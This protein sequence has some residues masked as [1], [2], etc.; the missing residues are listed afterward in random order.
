MCKIYFFFLEHPT[1]C[2]A[3]F[4]SILALITTIIFNVRDHKHKRLSVRPFMS[5]STINEVDNIIEVY[6]YNGG[7]GPAILEEIEYTIN[8]KSFTDFEYLIE[9]CFEHYNW[10]E[11]LKYTNEYYLRSVESYSAC[12]GDKLVLFKGDYKELNDHKFEVF[13]RFI[14]SVSVKVVYSDI[15]DKQYVFETNKKS[16]NK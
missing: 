3:V 11:Y 4:I 12:S 2:M 15:Y 13:L 1:E 10:V 6:L 5:I 14:Y 16:N 9:D 8:D 7:T